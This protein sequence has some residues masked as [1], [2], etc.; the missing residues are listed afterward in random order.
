MNFLKNLLVKEFE[1]WSTFAEKKASRLFLLN[2]VHILFSANVFL[3]YCL[4]HYAALYV[5]ALT[6]IFLVLM[7]GIICKHSICNNSDCYSVILVQC[8]KM[9]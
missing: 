8:V 4:C 6:V 5:I 9:A 2:K 7:L 3:Y 1:N